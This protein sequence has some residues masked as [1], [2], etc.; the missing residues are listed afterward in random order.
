MKIKVDINE[1]YEEDEIIIKCQKLSEEI[2]KLQ[3][4]I[5]NRKVNINHI[6]LF[7]DNIEYYE[8]IRNIIFFETED[9]VI[10]AHT[11]DDIFTTKKRLYELE[12]MLPNYFC[13]ISK[14]AIVNAKEIY[15]I[16]KNITAASKI[17]FRDS[18]KHIFVSRGY[19]K[20]LK[21]KINEMRNV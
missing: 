15:S 17:E 21:N 4:M 11:R 12:E 3:Q 8:D 13:R 5:S 14:S 10:K 1:I 19:Y 16:S 2:V 9:D 18:Y 20:P 6:E 7:K